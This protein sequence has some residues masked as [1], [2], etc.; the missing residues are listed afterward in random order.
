[1]E[2]SPPNDE[3]KKKRRRA[4]QEDGQGPTEGETG[5]KDA[6]GHGRDLGAIE[7]INRVLK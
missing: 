2:I 6:T 7:A 3:T 5:R 4:W 1:M